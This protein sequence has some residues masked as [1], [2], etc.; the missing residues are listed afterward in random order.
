M[1]KPFSRSFLEYPQQPNKA[2]RTN[3]KWTL[4]PKLEK[5]TYYVIMGM[6]LVLALFSLFPPIFCMTKA[7]KKATHL[8]NLL[9]LARIHI[10]KEVLTSLH[11]LHETQREGERG[12]SKR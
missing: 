6:K 12:R 11:C 7:N 10:G 4:E 5:N 2:L 8:R 1:P 9:P 3:T